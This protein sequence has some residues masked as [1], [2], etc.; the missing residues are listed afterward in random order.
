MSSQVLE[1]LQTTDQQE[2]NGN[3]VADGSHY[4]DPE[5]VKWGAKIPRDP[6]PSGHHDQN[7]LGLLLEGRRW[8]LRCHVDLFFLIFPLRSVFASPRLGGTSCH[9]RTAIDRGIG[10]RHKAAGVTGEENHHL[11]DVLRL[12]EAPKWRE[13]SGSLPL[14]R[15]NYRK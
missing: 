11:R 5:G 15:W 1:K 3:A 8:C 6:A 7:S 9:R 2:D 4:P 10:A 12:G 14:L 13:H